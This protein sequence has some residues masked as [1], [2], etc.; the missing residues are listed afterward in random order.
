MLFELEQN[1]LISFVFL[2]IILIISV[3]LLCRIYANKRYNY[4]GS[5]GDSQEAVGFLE[6]INNALKSAINMLKNIFVTPEPEQKRTSSYEIVDD[7]DMGDV[8]EIYHNA[9]L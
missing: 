5:N 8:R 7:D 3:S 9:G 6:S 1:D 4:T 2:I